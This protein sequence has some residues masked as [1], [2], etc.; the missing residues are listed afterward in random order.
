MDKVDLAKPY[1]KPC[2]F[3]GETRELVRI[4]STRVDEGDSYEDLQM[5]KWVECQNC[6]AMGPPCDTFK[7]AVKSWN[8]RKN[9]RPELI[10]VVEH[11]H[12][13]TGEGK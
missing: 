7:E 6:G 4:E 3:C 5:E 1:L 9:G 10:R 8:G 2:P 12:D 11:D 13:L